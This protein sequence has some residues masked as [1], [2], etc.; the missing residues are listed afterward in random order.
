MTRLGLFL[1]L[2]AAIS[3]PLTSQT[4][5][6]EV[7]SVKPN[8]SVGQAGII[9][10]PNRPGQFFITNIPLRTIITFAYN[11]RDYELIGAPDW[12]RRDRFDITAKYPD[13]A[14]QQRD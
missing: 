13:G 11:I 2:I 5:K 14:N 8:N 9:S 1:V 3:V 6:F 10:G 12:T 4:R 7:V